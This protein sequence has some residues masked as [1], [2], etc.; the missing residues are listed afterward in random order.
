MDGRTDVY[1]DAHFQ[2]YRAINSGDAAAF[3]AADR[4]WHFCW[5]IFPPENRKIVALLD[6][7]PGWKRIHADKYAIVH[8]RDGCES[9]AR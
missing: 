6:R 7:M 1:G 2:N 5:A 8:V 4:K 9:A 3:A